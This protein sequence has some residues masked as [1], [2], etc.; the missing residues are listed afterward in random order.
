MEDSN[1]RKGKVT[2]TDG[3][4]EEIV[5]EKE[6]SIKSLE[7]ELERD[8]EIKQALKQLRSEAPFLSDSKS[9]LAPRFKGGLKNRPTLDELADF[10]LWLKDNEEKRNA[11]QN[12][13]SK[14]DKLK[15]SS[16]FD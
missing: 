6:L 10:F 12:A 3:N 4:G 11:S 5:V 9:S 13:K 1:M 16:I 2:E 8:R 15:S 14:D 7:D